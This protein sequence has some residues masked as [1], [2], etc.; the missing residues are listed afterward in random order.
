LRFAMVGVLATMLL[1]VLALLA[2]TRTLMRDLAT[3]Q[4]AR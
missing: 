1:G 4:A 2:G 3:A